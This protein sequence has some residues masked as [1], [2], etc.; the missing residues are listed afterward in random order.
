MTPR[1]AL[2]DLDGTL[3]DTIQDIGNAMNRVLA[4]FELPTHDIAFYK[5]AVGNGSERLVRRSLPEGGDD[6]GHEALVQ[7]C[8]GAFLDEYRNGLANTTRIYDGIPDLLDALKA[9]RFPM[10]ILS[11]KPHPFTI[12]L[13]DHLL[14]TWFFEFVAGS[15]P[16]VPK[17]PDPTAAV[18]ISR[19]LN[20]RPQD[21]LYFGDT[22]TDMETARAAGM[23]PIGVLW[24]FRGEAELRDAGA[25]ILIEHPQQILDRWPG[26]ES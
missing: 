16:G 9:R 23:V 8:Y 25:E 21:V 11:N 2:F 17:K 10:A 7:S 13:V 5:T 22:A 15:K 4:R 6:T 1:A 14:Y 24:G 26:G 3:L 12:R 19:H 18:E 20:V